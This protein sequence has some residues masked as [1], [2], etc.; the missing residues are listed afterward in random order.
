MIMEIAKQLTEW[1]FTPGAYGIYAILAAILFNSLREYRENR[2]LSSSDR[3]ARRE[4]FEKQVQILQDENREQ[5]ED[6]RKLR[7]EYD[8]YRQICQEE[9][10]DLR[11]QVRR[12]ENEQTGYKRRLDAQALEL[13]KLRGI[14]NPTFSRAAGKKP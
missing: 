4:G 1:G 14:E 13:G 2:K 9:T 3:Q 5:R 11:Q 10:N 6:M 8:G 12:L 7:D